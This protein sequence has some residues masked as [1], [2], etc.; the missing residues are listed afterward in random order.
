MS[1]AFTWQCETKIS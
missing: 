1:V